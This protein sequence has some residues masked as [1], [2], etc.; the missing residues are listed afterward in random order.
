MIF[1]YDANI[2]VMDWSAISA[3]PFYSIP[4]L[5][6]PEVGKHYGTYLNYLVDEVGV[7]PKDIHLVGNGLG[8]HVSGYAAREVKKGKIGR[9][10]GKICV[11]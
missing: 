4:M 7:R 8:A 1:R 9:I 2:F 10:T 5:A 11:N 6:T 3:N